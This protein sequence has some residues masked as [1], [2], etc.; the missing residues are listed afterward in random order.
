MN[1]NSLR[2]A[3]V[4]NTVVVI[5]TAACIGAVI[6]SVTQGWEFWVP[7]LIVCCIIAT[8]VLHIIQCGTWVFRENYYLIFCMIV[9]FYHGVH[10]SSFFDVAI[11]SILLM[12]IV[13]LLR[14]QDF[15][16]LVLAEFFILIVLQIVMALKHGEFQWDSLY[17]SRL[18]L[19]ITA[20]IGIYRV[21][22]D[23]VRNNRRDEEELELRNREKETTRV[24]M[25]DFLVNISHELRTPVN[26][27]NGLSTIIL[28]KE[29]REDILSI[30]DAG[31]R[32][33][34]Q[35]EDIQDYSEI[36]RGDV[37]LEEDKYMITSLLNDLIAGF[38]SWKKN[39]NIDLIVDLDPSVP[40][41]MRGDAGKISKVTRHIL[42]NAV[43]FTRRGGI[44]LKVSGIRRDYGIN[45]AIEVTDTGIGISR[46]DIDKISNGRFQANT[47]RNRS[48]GGIGLGFS[49]VYGFVRAMNGFVNIDS[50]KGK[51]TTVKVTIAQEII[52]PSPCLSVESDKFI[53]IAFHVITDK[54]KV[55]TLREFYRS[56]ATNLATGLR[57][58]LYSAPSLHELKKLMDRGDITHVFMGAEE[59]ECDPAYFDSLAAGDVTVAVSAHD[60][61]SVSRGS[62]VIVMPKPLFGCPVVKILSGD[63]EDL[64]LPP[65]EEKRPELEGVRA[66]VVDDE[67][68]NL[69]VAS[70]LFKEYG[71]IIET[72]ECGRDAIEKFS[73]NDFDIVFMDHMMPEMDGVEA[74]KRLREIAIEQN[75]IA[76]VVALTANAISGAREMFMREGFDGFMSKP[77]NINEFERTMNKV[78]PAGILDQEGGRA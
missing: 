77:I 13:T 14:R 70:G 62:H 74:M 37:K 7:P 11:V 36:Q 26:V 42:E 45:L 75:K 71:M 32:L 48:T 16:H 54:Y 30:Q 1:D 58:N 66:L 18:V 56:M 46:N 55:E 52:D 28:K 2:N 35:I 15:I 51:G 63:T 59:Y 40:A 21:L 61:F 24:E 43:K 4:H 72:A 8:W 39:K 29:N 12:V 60:G 23:I 41:L 3:R 19:H 10:S 27:I 78:L 50:K 20:E 6:E 47:K 76:R 49:I 68:M 22:N 65:A 38:Q 31:L 57:I 34:R 9:S 53:N 33:S 17:I 73:N 25:E 67:P 69:V 44:Y 64:L 5:I